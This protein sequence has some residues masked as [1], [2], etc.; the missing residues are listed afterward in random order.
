LDQ[1]C[2]IKGLA[3]LVQRHV[4]Q[5]LQARKGARAV[6]QAPRLG[7][8]CQQDAR[9]GGHSVRPS[10]EPAR[11]AIGAGRLCQCNDA[12]TA[13]AGLTPQRHWR[14]YP[15]PRSRRKTPMTDRM[16]EGQVALVTGAGRGLGRAFAE[17]LA[18]LGCNIA[19][20]GMRENGPSEYGGTQTLTDV[21]RAIAEAHRVRTVRILG[22]LTRVDD[23]E[24]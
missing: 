19:V 9:R 24:H 18:A 5:R 10:T 16:L 13:V 20:H 12:P 11:T 7:G 4:A 1:P 8:M 6:V 2:W 17:R 14:L 15:Y 3:S 21:A 23:I 22:D